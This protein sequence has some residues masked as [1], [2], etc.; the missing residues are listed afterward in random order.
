MTIAEGGNLFPVLTSEQGTGYEQHS[1][2]RCQHLPKRVENA[3]PLSGEIRH[4]GLAP[5][6]LDVGVPSR[7]PRSRTRYVCKNSR[8]GTTVPPVAQDAAIGDLNARRETQPHEV[9]LGSRCTNRIDI[10][11][12]EFHVGQF[13]DVGRLSS[14]RRAGIQYPLAGCKIQPRR[15]QLRT[16]ILNGKPTGRRSRQAR[17]RY[18]T[19]KHNAVRHFVT[20]GA[21]THACRCKF[22]EH[23]GGSGAARIYAERHRWM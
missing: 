22:R 14:R 19:I 1:A 7:H 8:E 17:D 5:Q 23:A 12:R 18:R 4:V 9:R 16:D 21:G 13:K 10:E 15:R 2:T 20:A 6:P 3:A 11:R